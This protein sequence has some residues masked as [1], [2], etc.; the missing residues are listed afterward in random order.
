VAKQGK[1]SALVC[2]NGAVAGGG[3]PTEVAAGA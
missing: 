3:H 2:S 1:S